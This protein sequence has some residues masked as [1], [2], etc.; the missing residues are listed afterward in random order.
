MGKNE[1]FDNHLIIPFKKLIDALLER[2][3]IPAVD[4]DMKLS[5][6]SD[7]VV[8]VEKFKPDL[9]LPSGRKAT[10]KAYCG[11][12]IRCWFADWKL[13]YARQKKNIPFEECHEVHLCKIN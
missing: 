3:R 10:G 11:V 13:K 8:R 7:L 2:Y 5:I 12:L 9:V 6:L 1:I 4:D